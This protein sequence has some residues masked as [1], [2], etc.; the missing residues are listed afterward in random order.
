MNHRIDRDEQAGTHQQSDGLWGADKLRTRTDDR[1]PLTHRTDRIALRNEMDTPIVYV[2]DDPLFFLAPDE[3]SMQQSLLKDGIAD[4]RHQHYA[5]EADDLG[6][7]ETI[8]REIID[9]FDAD[10]G[11]KFY[12]GIAGE[13]AQICGNGLDD[14]FDAIANFRTI[15][16]DLETQLDPTGTYQ[17]TGFP[18]ENEYMS[19]QCI[20]LTSVEGFWLRF[21]TRMTEA[22]DEEYYSRTSVSVTSL[23]QH[24]TLTTMWLQDRLDHPA[25]SSPSSVDRQDAAAAQAKLPLGPSPLT[26]VKHH[27]LIG[28][29]SRDETVEYIT[30]ENPY[31]RAEQTA[32]SEQFDRLDDAGVPR[33]VI[34]R[35]INIDRIPLRPR[36]GSHGVDEDV[37]IKGAFEITQFGTPTGPGA[38]GVALLS[39]KVNPVLEEDFAEWKM[40]VRAKREKQTRGFLDR[41]RL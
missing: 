13:R 14:Y 30:C 21:N 6:E 10:T 1:A 40:A 24:G 3:E 28:Y 20:G 22:P 11:Q 34:R 8:V 41:L 32:R 37:F 19:V 26:D 35:V 39:G 18:H 25:L 29:R 7:S 36:G 38:G 16:T 23:E 27:R 31:Y 33:D 5:V 2:D 15:Y 9:Q 12:Y 4:I 17:R